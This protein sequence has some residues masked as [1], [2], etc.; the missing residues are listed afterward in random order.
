MLVVAAFGC[1]C[2]TVA[3]IKS[4]LLKNKKRETEE[5]SETDRKGDKDVQFICVR[6]RTFVT[7]RMNLIIHT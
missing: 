3:Q 6:M 7:Y 1:T 4:R 2:L 5:R